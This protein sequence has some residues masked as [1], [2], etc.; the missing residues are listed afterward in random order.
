MALDVLLDGSSRCG[1]WNITQMVAFA[2]KLYGR[3]CQVD[4]QHLTYK[5]LFLVALASACHMSISSFREIDVDSYRT[6]M[7]LKFFPYFSPLPKLCPWLWPFKV[8]QG[9]VWWCQWTPHICFLLIVNSNMWPNLAA[10]RD[11]RLWNLGDL[12]LSRSLKVK[13]DGVIG[14]PICGFLLMVNSNLIVTL[15]DIIVNSNFMRYKALKSEW[16]WLWPFKSLKVKCHGVIE[17]A[18]YCVLLM[19]NSNIRPN[20]APLGDIRLLK[21]GWPWLCPFKVTQGQMVQLDSPCRSSYWC[22]IVTTCL[23]PTV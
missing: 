5:T 11:T 19:V 23:S 13:C 4:M 12:D 16:P 20:L 17:L 1:H 3:L 8:T 21:S 2:E 10:L 15:R 9:Q 18:M 22:L 7:Q 6:H 14:L